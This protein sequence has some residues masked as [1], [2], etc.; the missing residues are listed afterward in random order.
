M[1]KLIACLV[2]VCFVASCAK[3]VNKSD[4][5]AN[6]YSETKKEEAVKAS[7]KD[8][9]ASKKAKKAKKHGGSEVK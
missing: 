2:A 9:K 5:N 8:A 3:S 1:K 7:K 6:K 4:A